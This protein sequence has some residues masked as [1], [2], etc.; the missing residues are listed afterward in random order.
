MCQ[1]DIP[2]TIKVYKID[3]ARVMYQIDLSKT[4]KIYKIDRK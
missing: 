4:I 3:N 2:K 1:S